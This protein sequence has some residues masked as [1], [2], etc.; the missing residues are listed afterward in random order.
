MTV[1]YESIIHKQLMDIGAM[2]FDAS[3]LKPYLDE[4]RNKHSSLYGYCKAQRAALKAFLQNNM[5]TFDSRAY[6][7]GV[8]IPED[9]DSIRYWLFDIKSFLNLS[10]RA[11]CGE[12]DED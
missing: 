7:M 11:V 12:D 8:G 4:N 1:P 2:R 9:V 5:E 10:E 6:D 3:K